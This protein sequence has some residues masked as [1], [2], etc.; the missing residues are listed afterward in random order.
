MASTSDW[1]DYRDYTLTA[2]TTIFTTPPECFDR[3]LTLVSTGTE[4][5]SYSDWSTDVVQW[6]AY[7]FD[8]TT[9]L[10]CYPPTPAGPSTTFPG[11]TITIWDHNYFSPAACPHDHFMFNATSWTTSTSGSVGTITEATCCPVGYTS[12]NYFGCTSH[13]ASATKALLTE[14]IITDSQYEGS[15]YSVTGSATLGTDLPHVLIRSIYSVAWESSDLSL[16]TP[17]SA[18][19]LQPSGTSQ[20][21]ASLSSISGDSAGASLVST[22]GSSKKRHGMSSKARITAE[23]GAIVGFLGLLCLLSWFLIRQRLLRKKE[24]AVANDG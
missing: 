17:A 5:A 10:S 8:S 18:P 14:N 21:S 13:F 19:I 2:L 23:V 20:M 24:S 9:A 7:E 1:Q 12:H 22:S 16:F 6:D 4:D 15:T 11:Q 3:P